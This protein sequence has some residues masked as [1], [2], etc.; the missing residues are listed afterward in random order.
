MSKRA[1]EYYKNYTK[2]GFILNPMGT[3]EL[4]EAYHQS[5]VNSISDN[6]I[7]SQAIRSTYKIGSIITLAYKKGARWFKNKLLKKD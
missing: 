3:F 4:M 2:N 6:D 5:R 7:N 1:E